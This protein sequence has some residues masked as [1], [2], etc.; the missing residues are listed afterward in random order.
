[1]LPAGALLHP[2]GLGHL[3]HGVDD[4]PADTRNVNVLFGTGQ[5]ASGG[6]E[7]MTAPAHWLAGDVRMTRAPHS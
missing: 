3:A 2:T 5:G 4:G 7:L 6:T 1:V